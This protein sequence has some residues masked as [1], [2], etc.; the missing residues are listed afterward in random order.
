MYAVAETRGKFAKES[1]SMFSFSLHD[2]S[3]W[4]AQKCCQSC[5]ILSWNLPFKTKVLVILSP[6]AL[7]LHNWI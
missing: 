2:S 5:Q 1:W 3:L 7:M 4:N 6:I